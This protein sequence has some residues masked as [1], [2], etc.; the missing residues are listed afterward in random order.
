[1]KKILYSI[2]FASAM[3]LT[4]SVQAQKNTD[5]VL[6]S[7]G[8]NDVT[9]GEFLRMYT[10][11]INNQKP[12][13]SEKALREYLTL[14]SRFKMKVAEAE[15]MQMD[16]LP[17]IK[18]ELGTYKKQLAKTYLTDNEVTDKLVK[19]AYDR[20]KKDVH[21]AH[22]LI[23]VPRGTEDTVAAFRKIDSLYKAVQKGADFGAIA[24][25]VSDDKPSGA[26]GGDVGYFTALQIPAYAFESNAY[27]TPAGGVSLP[28]RTAF[29]YHIIKKLDE[30][31]SRGEI[32][33]AQIMINVKKSEGEAGDKAGKAKID[34]ILTALKKGANFDNLVE[35]FS[36]DKFS[37]N[38]KGVLATFGVGQMVPEFENAAF[39]LN[40]PGSLSEPVKTEYGYHIIKLINKTPIRPFDSMKN[41]LKKRIEKDGRI[42]V[43]REQYTYKIK[44]KLNYK[45]YPAALMELINAIPDST[46]RN[47]TFNGSDYKQYNK[48]LFEMTG[49]VFT[50]SD[51]AHYIQD[52]TKGKIYGAKEVTLKS[53][54][55]NYN[56]KALYDFQE[57]KLIDENEEYRNLLTEYKDGIMLFELTDRMV[58]SKASQ[59]TTGLDQFYKA[60]KSKYMWPANLVKANLYRTQDEEYAKRVVKALNDPKVNQ[61]Q[62]EVGKA[63]NGDGPQ[64]K[65]VYEN[66][67]FERSRFPEKLKLEAGKYAPYYKNDDGSYSIVDVKE[68]YPEPTQKTL[69]EA[70]GYVISDYQE[71][72]EKQWIASLEATYPVSVKEATLKSMIK[73]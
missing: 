58:W 72:L 22:I 17:T 59:D 6:F 33:V 32:Q 70:R 34:S 61:T 60:N 5:P 56:E 1:M 65:V 51:F 14:Y 19:E 63:A 49:T 69:G 67:K 55:K 25:A 29:G 71:Y 13:Y 3:M 26:K 44:Q 46:L 24:K 31:N 2:A 4:L 35:R 15:K 10:K 64:N 47:G 53:L 28:F 50:Q 54:F 16:T 9:K 52:Y 48:N 12:D 73:K 18:T 20:M 11:N 21:V 37:K 30:R 38:T 68:I 62:E 39:A 7:Y 40:T 41:E 66:G 42:D 8:G 27:T 23:N 57:N 43:A 45:D 36:D